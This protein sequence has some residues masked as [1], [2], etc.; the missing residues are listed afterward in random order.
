MRCLLLLTVMLLVSAVC[1]ADVVIHDKKFDRDCGVQV[2]HD[3]VS[4]RAEWSLGDA[5]SAELI[6]DL[7]P[8]QPLIRSL[9]VRAPNQGEMRPVIQGA[10]PLLLLA[11]GERDLSKKDG[12]VQFFDNPYRRPHE[13]HLARLE[14]RAVE[15]SSTERR[16]TIQVDGLTAGSFRGKFSIT[17]Y[18]DTDLIR[19]EAALVTSEDGRAIA[20]DLGLTTGSMPEHV[21]YLDNHDQFHREPV[22][23]QT[24]ATQIEV[25]HRTLA[26][27]NSA[28][29]LSIFPPPHQFLYPLDFADNYGLVW[30]GRD[31]RKQADQW[32]FGVT[33]P[34]EGDRRFVPWTNAPPGSVQRLSAFC[35]LTPGRAEDCLD[36]VKKYTRSD[37]FK[38]LDGYHTF[39]SHYHIEHTLELLREQAAA[40]SSEIPASLRQPP[41][42]TAFKNQGVDIVH[43]AEFHVGRKPEFFAQRLPNLRLM[44]QECERL[45]DES[46]LVLPGEEPNAHLGGHWISFFPKPV[47]WTFQRGPDEPFVEDVP[48]YGKVYRVGSPDDALK[49]MEA[50]HGLMWTAHPRIKSSLGF[51]DQYRQ[52][53]FYTSDRFLGAAWKAMP[54]DLSSPRLG[55]R[56]LDLLDDM[57][58]WGQ[59]KY[60]LGEVDVFRVQPDYELYGHSNVNYLQL[61]RVPRF[62]DGW[63]GI[64]DTLR[65]GRFFVTTGEVLIPSFTLDGQS[66]GE[67]LNL[68]PDGTAMLEADLEWT[69]PLSFAEVISGDGQSVTRER[70][71]LEDTGPFGTRRLRVPLKLAGRKWARLEVWDIAANGAFTQPVWIEE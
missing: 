53:P 48:P 65:G 28:G 38:K 21:A 35:V 56:S 31:W 58:N 47:Y 36:R 7:R 27:E 26:I 42:V 71:R 49:L 9:S 18:A 2:R 23:A 12:W 5:G 20:Y 15:V 44:H 3:K 8:A 34:R 24:P 37:R 30:R 17:L 66:S 46:L 25:R 61:D 52:R 45:S 43:L 57:A 29:S 70:I 60:V 68:K 63:Q 10:D 22:T 11:V 39:S 59:R 64:L 6:L 62:K 67:T 50:E 14:K 16:A 55:S 13:T 69:F 1:A 33:Q 51:P 54:A 4:L 19:L 40:N 32:S 41:F